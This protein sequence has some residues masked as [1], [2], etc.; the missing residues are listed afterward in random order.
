MVVGG[1]LLF[2]NNIQTLRHSKVEPG[3][4]NML[5]IPENMNTYAEKHSKVYTKNGI[6]VHDVLGV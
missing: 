2:R 4:L 1:R 5:C 3:I 6:V